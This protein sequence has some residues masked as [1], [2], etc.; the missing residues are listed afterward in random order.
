MHHCFGGTLPLREKGKSGPKKRSKKIVDILKK[1]L[2]FKNT[3][4]IITLA[5]RR[6]TFK[7]D[8]KFE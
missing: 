6:T 5:S 7:R 4:H 1:C 3:S 2:H 8:S